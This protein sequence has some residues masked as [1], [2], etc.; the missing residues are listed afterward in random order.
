MMLRLLALALA[1]ISPRADVAPFLATEPVG[2]K[3]GD[4][5]I[6]VNRADPEESLIVGIDEAPAP[7]GAL[8]VFGLNGRIRESMVGIDSPAGVDV[9]YG[10]DGADIIVVTERAKNRLLVFRI[11]SA[12]LHEAGAIEC[13][14]EPSAIA[15]YRRSVDGTIFAIVAASNEGLLQFRL[16]PREDGTIGGTR[17]RQFGLRR[18]PEEIDAIA[19]DDELGFVYCSVKGAGIRKFRAEPDHPRA[20]RTVSRFGEPGVSSDR[21]SL[22]MYRSARGRGYLISRNRGDGDGEFLV[23]R[24]EGANRELFAFRGGAEAVNA[25]EAVPE[26]LGE[27]LPE[28]IF[29]AASAVSRSFLIYR[30]QDV[31]RR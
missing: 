11:D 17:V 3:A 23:Y 9:A 21:E 26:N 1:V 2:A 31:V 5:A 10:L 7:N 28:G 30:W 19:V 6:W 24:R 18:N 15:L 25:I 12:G 13:C 4:V 22:A 27:N 8:V 14:S 29:V 20:R 16:A